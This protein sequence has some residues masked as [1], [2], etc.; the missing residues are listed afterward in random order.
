MYCFVFTLFF[1]F[2]SFLICGFGLQNM[3]LVKMIENMSNFIHN[4]KSIDSCI[5]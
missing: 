3:Q 2:F 1:L 4:K 5:I